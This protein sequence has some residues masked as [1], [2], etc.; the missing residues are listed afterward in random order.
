MK[1]KKITCHESNVYDEC[2]RN[3]DYCMKVSLGE[4]TW[5]NFNLS[6]ESF[7]ESEKY[8]FHSDH[9]HPMSFIDCCENMKLDPEKT[10]KEFIKVYPVLGV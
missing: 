1:F 7:L 2:F 10:R 9:W 5:P 8:W 3:F 6:K 4:R